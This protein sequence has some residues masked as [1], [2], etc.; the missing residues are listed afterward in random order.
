M[1]Y[2]RERKHKI[3]GWY[4]IVLEDVLSIEKDGDMFVLWEECDQCYTKS[5]TKKEAIELLQEAIDWVKKQ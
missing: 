4:G 5:Y 3:N 2:F 1:K